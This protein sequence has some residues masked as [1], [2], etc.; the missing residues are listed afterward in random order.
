MAHVLVLI[1]LWIGAP[2]ILRFAYGSSFVEVAEV[3]RLLMLASFSVWSAG[4]V[5]ISGLNGMG[6][7]RIEYDRENRRRQRDD[8]DVDSL[9]SDARNRR[10]GAGEYLR[11]QR[12]V[13]GRVDMSALAPEDRSVGMRKTTLG[14]LARDSYGSIRLGVLWHPFI[15]RLNRSPQ[16]SFL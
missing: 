14:R 3:W 5:V 4:A 1:P 7:P 11:L 13:C 2:H 6:H 12:D 8:R 15:A 9:A 10:G 16:K